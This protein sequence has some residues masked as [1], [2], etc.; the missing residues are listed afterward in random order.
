DG[1][2]LAAAHLAHLGRREIVDAAPRQQDLAAGDAARRLQQADDRRAGQRLA[3]PRLADHAQHLAGRDRERDV[4]E[5]EQGAAAGGELHAQVA[6]FE[7]SR[8]CSL[9]LSAS[10]SQSPSR[11]T[12]MHSSTSARPGDITS[13]HSPEKRKVLPLLI[14]VPSE[15]EGGGTPT[16]REGSGGTGMMACATLIV[17]MTSTGPST[18]GST[19]RIMIR[20]GFT[21]MTRAACTYSLPCSTSVEPRT[22]RAYCT[23]LARPIEPTSTPIASQSLCA[24]RGS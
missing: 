20:Q 12:D 15:G 2:D 1:A 14:I 21:P 6:D 5:R 24:S 19:W 7:K 10:R 4:V 18:L 9:G 17:A 23:Q 8:H 16:P 11:L 3:G 13:H 22:V